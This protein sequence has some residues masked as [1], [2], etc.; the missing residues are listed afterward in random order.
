MVE[1]TT[2]GQAQPFAFSANDDGIS[3]RIR[4]KHDEW[5]PICSSLDLW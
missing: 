2:P 5:T 1:D 3:H 4:L